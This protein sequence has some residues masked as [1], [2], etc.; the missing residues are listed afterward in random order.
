M[1]PP[2]GNEPD[3]RLEWILS[4]L[5][6]PARIGGM[7]NTLWW[8]AGTGIYC[9]ELVTR[10]QIID[11]RICPEP[12]ENVVQKT[13]ENKRCDERAGQSAG[14]ILPIRRVLVLYV[15]FV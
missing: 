13:V 5:F 12:A 8:D 9:E 15:L 6:L 10:A 4:L 1:P 3:M 7:A 14:A 2:G 11:S